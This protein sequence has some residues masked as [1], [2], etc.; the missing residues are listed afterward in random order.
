MDRIIGQYVHV[1]RIMSQII[2]VHKH[3]MRTC[4]RRAS[5]PKMFHLNQPGQKLKLTLLTRF[6]GVPGDH[7][8]EAGDQRVL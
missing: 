4:F 2:D 8:S 5:S 3:Q 1:I 7:R 6:V